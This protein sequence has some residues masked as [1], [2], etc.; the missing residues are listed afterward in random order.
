M[1]RLLYLYAHQSLSMSDRDRNAVR[2]GIM[3]A[4]T[5]NILTFWEILSFIDALIYIP[6]T[7]GKVKD[8]SAKKR[9]AEDHICN[10]RMFRCHVNAIPYL[11]LS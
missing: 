4:E 10:S 11:H 6:K 8:T 7:L 5:A 2:T 3:N 1:L 9:K